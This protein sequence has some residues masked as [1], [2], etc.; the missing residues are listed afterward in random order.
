MCAAAGGM[1]G[2]GGGGGGAASVRR[3]AGIAVPACAA[4]PVAF[5][6]AAGADVSGPVVADV[7]ADAREAAAAS[8]SFKSFSNSLAAAAAFSAA[9]L[10]LDSAG[11]P[12]SLRP[13]DLDEDRERR[14]CGDAL[15]VRFSLGLLRRVRGDG[16][17]GGFHRCCGELP[18]R[19]VP[20]RSARPP[21]ALSLERDRPRP[22]RLISSFLLSFLRREEELLLLRRRERL[23][24]ISM[25]RPPAPVP[26]RLRLRLRCA[27]FLRLARSE[28]LRDAEERALLREL[29][30]LRFA[31]RS[32]SRSLSL[33]FSLSLLDFFFCFAS[34]C[35]ALR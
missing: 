16:E 27:P 15:L 25:R 26:E 33:S 30:F 34:D 18:R 8:F 29:P 1:M 19:S 20:P 2:G 13:A 3:A 32:R 28:W 21:L 23:L 17:F 9:V 5:A 35:D 4:G 31:S 22:A 7:A 10:P 24:R 6:G 11:L 12:P 14:L